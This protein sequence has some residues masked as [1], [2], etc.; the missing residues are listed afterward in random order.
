VVTWRVGGEDSY[1]ELPDLGG[2]ECP[3]CLHFLDEH[4]DCKECL[5]VAYLNSLPD[6]DDGEWEAEGL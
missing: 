5:L 3:E 2:P 6:D 1:Y 4:G